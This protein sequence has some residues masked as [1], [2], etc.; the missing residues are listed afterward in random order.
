MQLENPISI[1]DLRSHIPVPRGHSTFELYSC[2]VYIKIRLWQGI[3]MLTLQGKKLAV[4]VHFTPLEFHS[5]CRSA[6]V[7]SNHC[8]LWRGWAITQF[9]L[10]FVLFNN[11]NAAG[12]LSCILENENILMPEDCFHLNHN[13]KFNKPEAGTFGYFSKLF[14]GAWVWEGYLAS[15]HG[16]RAEQGGETDQEWSLPLCPWL[17]WLHCSG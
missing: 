11:L 7:C 5:L 1:L 14:V 9:Y 8:L 17:I 13:I 15:C 3:V 16:R 4:L 12:G 6:S 10:L 2:T